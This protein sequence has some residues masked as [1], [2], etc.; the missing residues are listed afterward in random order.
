MILKVIN[1]SV[2]YKDENRPVLSDISF[3][4]NEGERV[5]LFGLNGSGKTT[6]ML[7]IVGLLKYTGEIYF[8][9][10]LISN[11]NIEELREK[12]GFLF[13]IPDDQ[14]LFPTVLEDISFTMI[15]KGISKSEANKKAEKIASRLGIE[16]YL[17]S[18]TFNLSY[19]ERLKVALG[20]I[21]AAEPELLLLDE[22]SSGLDPPAKR[23][24]CDLM[25]GLDSTQLIATHD[26][27][28]ALAFCNR[29][30]LLESGRLIME[31]SEFDKIRRYWES[32]R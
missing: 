5:A 20:G 15:R 2:Y 16:R 19:G 17:N 18:Y 27:D 11:K 21:L 24:L 23:R 30:L 14:I 32:Q 12:T 13:S 22:P 6:L 25:S 9:G 29:Y 3:S 4:V 8:K 26:I 1:L 31:G 28:F 10:N 7:A